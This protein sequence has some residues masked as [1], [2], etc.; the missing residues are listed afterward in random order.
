MRKTD[1]IE[2]FKK[3]YSLSD[4][5]WNTFLNEY[6][7]NEL[8][9]RDLAEKYKLNYNSLRYLFY[10][11]G[12]VNSSKGKRIESVLELQ[13]DLAKESGAEYNLVEE[14]EKEIDSIVG[15]NRAL[16]K[17]LNH[18]RD[19]N[20][21][22]RK[23]VRKEDRVE[24]FEEKILEDFSQKLSSLEIKKFEFTYKAL[25][26]PILERGTIL[27]LGDAHFGDESKEEVCGNNFNYNIATQRLNY[28]LDTL[29]NYPN[30]SEIL[31]VFELL[32]IT[33]GLIHFGEYLSEGGI[34]G[35]MLKVVEVYADVYEKLSP[36]YK[37]IEVFV[38]NSNHD[39]TTQKPTYRDKWDNFG[40]MLMKMVEMVLKAKNI[41]N[42]EF[43]YT[44]KEYHLVNINGS[45]LLGFHGDTVRRY[46]PSN[47]SE[48]TNLQSICYGLFK[49]NY[50]IAVSGHIHQS[51]M[52]SN[53]FGGYNIV[54]G[55]LG[56]NSEYGITNGYS[57]IEPCQ[58][59]MFINDK[60][61]VQDLHFINLSHIQN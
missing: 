28:V 51:A 6:E 12:F 37:K 5:Q 54:N 34:T 15:K 50:N 48:R 44:K 1:L 46:N 23:L 10:T 9:I 59:I 25:P 52:V 30:Q 47:K 61:K 49:D 14:L 2:E 8:S 29:L 16:V 35:T 56:G 32:D 3:R 27:L 45:N 55:S 53:E 40:V 38:T 21:H 57:S 31:T 60:G 20:N 17:S 43:N 26:E 22:L 18:S 42:V 7:N 41:T 11:L 58:T 13:K 4:T 24:S 36:A 39:R 33:K 19:E